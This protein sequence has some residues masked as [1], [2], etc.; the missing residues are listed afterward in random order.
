[1]KRAP[2]PSSGYGKPRG[3]VSQCRY[4]LVHILRDWIYSVPTW[5]SGSLIVVGAVT[6]SLLALAGFHQFV[7]L[8]LRRAHNDVAGFILAIV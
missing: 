4:Y 2:R 8:E 7:P 5:L 1:M 3:K 6:L